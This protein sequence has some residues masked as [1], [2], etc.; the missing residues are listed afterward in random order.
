MT[1]QV[2]GVAKYFPLMLGILSHYQYLGVVLLGAI[3]FILMYCLKNNYRC[4]LIISVCAALIAV[5]YLIFGLFVYREL[6]AQFTYLLQNNLKDQALSEIENLLYI[7][8]WI[9]I[10]GLLLLLLCFVVLLCEK[11]ICKK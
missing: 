3:A 5:L 1:D 8:S 6:L 11:R 4:T 9:G 7:Q 2:A 10:I